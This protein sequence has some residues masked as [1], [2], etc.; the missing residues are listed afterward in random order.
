MSINDYVDRLDGM[1]MEA[2][3]ESGSVTCCPN[4]PDVSIRVG[5][6]RTEREAYRYAH[7]N[8]KRVELPFPTSDI[9]QAVETVLLSAAEGR[10]PECDKLMRD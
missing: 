1:A 6:E 7:A 8:N 9:T 4:H 3:C 2:C 10:C 5:D